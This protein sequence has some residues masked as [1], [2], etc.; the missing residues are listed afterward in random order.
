MTAAVAG[1][2][3]TPALAGALAGAVVVATT[4]AATAAV[5]ATRFCSG[6]GFGFGLGDF[7]LRRPSVV[8]RVRGGG[9]RGGLGRQ[10]ADRDILPLFL[11]PFRHAEANPEYMAA[12]AELCRFFG[13]DEIFRAA[14][15]EVESAKT[16]R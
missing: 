10:R 14:G 15:C 7:G 16:V 5:R 6:F 12:Q 1:L 3:A 11:D 9:L 4:G 13:I 2:D 8:R